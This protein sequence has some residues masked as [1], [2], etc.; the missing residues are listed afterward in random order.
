MVG[1]P[2]IDR[3]RAAALTARSTCAAL[4]TCAAC[5]TCTACT[6]LTA[7]LPAAALTAAALTAVAAH[8]VCRLA[9]RKQLAQHAD[10]VAHQITRTVIIILAHAAAARVQAQLAL[11]RTVGIAGCPGL[12]A[13]GLHAIATPPALADG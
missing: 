8:A 5:T 12:G 9:N 4:A 3:G 2:R 1:L 6:A 10:L 13:I 11:T 7:T